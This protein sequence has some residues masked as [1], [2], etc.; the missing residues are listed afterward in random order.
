M[1]SFET[2]RS[3]KDCELILIHTSSYD[4]SIISNIFLI[5]SFNESELGFTIAVTPHSTTILQEGT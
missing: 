1:T 2:R 4:C 3:R 5:Q